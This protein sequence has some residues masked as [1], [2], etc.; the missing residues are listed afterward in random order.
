MKTPCAVSA[1]LTEYTRPWKLITFAIGM[2]L[3]VVGALYNLA[4][5]WDVPISFIM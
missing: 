2:A 3:S 1:L 4:P 5:D